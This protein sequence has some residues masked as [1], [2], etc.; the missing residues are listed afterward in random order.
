MIR[1]IEPLIG[2][3]EQKA[4]QKYLSSGGFLTEFK[5]TEEFE[6]KLAEFLGVKYVSCVPSGTVALYLSLLASGLEPGS[7]VAVPDITMIA[8]YNA[9]VAAGM[10]PVL[11]DVDDFGCLNLSNLKESV[12]A[13]IYVELNGYAPQLDRIR[14]LCKEEEI[15]LIEDS[16]QALGSKHKG[17]F[18][19]TFSRFGC[20]SLSFHKIITTGQGGFIV[21]HNRKDYETIEKLK[22]FGRLK[23]GNDIHDTFGLNFKFTDL[24]AVIGLEQLKTIEWRMKKK[25]QIFKWYYGYEAQ[26]GYVPWFIEVINEDTES[27]Q[28][29]LKAAGIE[30]R[31]MYPP[32]HTQKSVMLGSLAG[33]DVFPSASVYSQTTLWLPSSL[34]LTKEE[35]NQINAFI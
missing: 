29:E 25:R 35:V 9:V 26:E 18:L 12:D 5:K 28:A 10:V 21:S 24:Q 3:A 6:Q 17:K 16:C 4:M 23:G 27:I 11:V 7:R 14:K 33:Y 15:V 34:N 19:G 22:D 31:V 2:K 1:H 13:I 30:S 32:L 8:T 20:F